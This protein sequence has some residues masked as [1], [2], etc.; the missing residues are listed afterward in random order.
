MVRAEERGAVQ[1]EG[2]PHQISIPHFPSTGQQSP[3]G[4]K[5]NCSHWVLLLAAQY[6][7]IDVSV[8]FTISR[9]TAKFLAGPGVGADVVG[10][11][12]LFSH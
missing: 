7:K 6:V 5:S 9:E 1:A 4:R 11:H 10:M 12:L 8:I 3:A 2:A